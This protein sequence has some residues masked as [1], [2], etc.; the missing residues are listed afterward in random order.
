MAPR[1]RPA[2]RGGQSGAAPASPP[3]PS[4]R[5]GPTEVP[6]Q[7]TSGTTGFPRAY[8][9]PCDSGVV[10]GTQRGRTGLCGASGQQTG[11]WGVKGPALR[12]ADPHLQ[13]RP[14]EGR[15]PLTNS[16]TGHAGQD[17]ECGCA[18][19]KGVLGP[20]QGLVANACEAQRLVQRSW[21][22][23]GPAIS[24]ANPQPR[25]AVAGRGVPPGWESSASPPP[26]PAPSQRLRTRTQARELT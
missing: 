2:G 23:G 8:F 24:P 20:Q 21:R 4:P 9:Y 26:P 13:P 18:V 5:L 12:Y 19:D 25:P 14:G 16:A 22:H 10:F 15:G 1:L 7:E 17:A 11:G 3:C 6:L